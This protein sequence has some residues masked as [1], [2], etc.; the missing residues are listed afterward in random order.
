MEFASNSQEKVELVSI[1]ITKKM[2]NQ[3]NCMEINHVMVVTCQEDGTNSSP[4][5]STRDPAS[6]KTT[7]GKATKSLGRRHTKMVQ[8]DWTLNGKFQLNVDAMTEE[9]D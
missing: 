3:A 4:E 8:R 6:R 9:F 1:R 5:Q 7:K 2:K